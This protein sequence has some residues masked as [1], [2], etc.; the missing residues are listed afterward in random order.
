MRGYDDVPKGSYA[1]SPGIANHM[2]FAKVDPKSRCR[3]DTGV[4]TRNLAEQ[5]SKSAYAA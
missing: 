3:I 2:C 5:K 4:D 1:T